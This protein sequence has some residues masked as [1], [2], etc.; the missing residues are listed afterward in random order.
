[1]QPAS[2]HRITTKRDR[3]RRARSRR[4]D[5]V[6]PIIVKPIAGAGSAHTF[7]VDGRADLES[8][9]PRLVGVPEVSVEEFID[10]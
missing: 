10:G 8:V 9:L 1:M 6:V 3:G 2:A 5:R 7:R 4:T